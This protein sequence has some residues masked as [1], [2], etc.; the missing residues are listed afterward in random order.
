MISN[1]D[2]KCLLKFLSGASDNNPGKEPDIVNL[3]RTYNIDIKFENFNQ[4]YDIIDEYEN[5]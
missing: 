3:L 2:E 1:L 5:N 4:I